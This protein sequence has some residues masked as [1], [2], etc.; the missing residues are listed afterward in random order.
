[1][2]FLGRH[3]QATDD[4]GV[5][6]ARD[7]NYSRR[8][9]AKTPGTNGGN[10]VTN[11]APWGIY[12]IIA[13]VVLAF[14]LVNAFSAAHD[15]VRRGGSYDLSRPLLWDMT[16]AVVIVALAPLINFGVRR[17]GRESG[18]PTRLCWVAGTILV[19]SALHIAG[20]VAL[21][22]LTMATIGG[23][24]SFGFS[25]SE[26]I[27]EFRKDAVTCFMIGTAFWLAINRRDAFAEN[28]AEIISPTANS[29]QVLWLR[30]GS[31]RIRI[32]PREIVAVSSAG[33]YV[34]YSLTGGRSH[35]VRGTLAAEEARLTSFNIVRVHRTRL[36]NLSRVTAV[37]AGPNGDFELTLDTGQTISGS[38]RYRGA[39]I[40][41]EQ[42]AASPGPISDQNDTLP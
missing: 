39:V 10:N 12:A 11:G 13:A 4:S 24:Y 25:I 5:E 34:E 18:W 14:A 36:I 1:M 35:L 17:M 41:I 30:D 16:S 22:K 28:A 3:I 6:P 15:A 40:S 27:Y 26:L 33:N 23:S 38:R 20:M 8:D 31:A 2:N 42:L 37:K 29:P 7:R 32:E 19:F 9:Q 21:R